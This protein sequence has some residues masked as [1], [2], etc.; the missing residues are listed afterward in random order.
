MTP[1]T[2]MRRLCLTSVM[3]VNI[4]ELLTYFDIEESSDYGDT[5]AAIAVVGEDLGA[6]LFQHYCKHVRGSEAQVIDA[7]EEIPTTGKKKGPRLDRWI[8]EQVGEKQILYQS[9]IKSWC[10]RAIGG[11]NVSLNISDEELLQA[12]R[13]NWNN[14]HKSLNNKEINGVN[15]V[16]VEMKNDDRLGIEGRYKKE[17]LLIFWDARSPS[18][19]AAC[20]GRL[21]LKK[22]YFDYD[23][24]WVFSCSLYLRYLCRKGVRKLSLAI[25]NAKRRLNDLNRL[26]MVK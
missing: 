9:E 10:A 24:C 22:P 23:Y 3:Q 8:L 26:F 1:R 25:P 14:V 13:R 17:P 20:L 18:N 6:A 15:K 12:T 7:N 4:K 16:L 11:S 5:T 21:K 2:K 19:R